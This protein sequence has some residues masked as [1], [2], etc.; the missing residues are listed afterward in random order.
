MR[1]FALA[2]VLVACSAPSEISDAGASDSG[3]RADG[4]A[5]RDASVPPPARCEAPALYDVSRPTAVVGDGTPASCTEEALSDAATGGGTIVFD[6][7]PEPITITVSSPITFTREA[8]LDGGGL[9]TLSGGET[10]R[11]L[12]LDSAYDRTTPRLVVQ[13]LTF[14]DGHSQPGGDD[15]AVGGGASIATEGA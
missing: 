12:H 2:F 9:V 15:T 13:R 1:R 11:I 7:G 8:V 3:A 5:S 4:G 6:C 10:S 14:R